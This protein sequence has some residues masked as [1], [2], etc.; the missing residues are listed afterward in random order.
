MAKKSEDIKGKNSC[1]AIKNDFFISYHSQNGG[2]LVAER[3]NNALKA[4]KYMSYYNAEQHTGELYPIRLHREVKNCKVLLW[5]LTKNALQEKQNNQPNWFFAELLWAVKYKKQIFFLVANN[6]NVEE[7]KKEDIRKKFKRSFAILVNHFTHLFVE[8]DICLVDKVIDEVLFPDKYNPDRIFTSNDKKKD[9]LPYNTRKKDYEERLEDFLFG[10]KDGLMKRIKKTP[11][12]KFHVMRNK[13]MYIYICRCML[14]VMFFFS[15]LGGMFKYFEYQKSLVI[16][17]GSQILKNGWSDVK[18]DGSKESPYQIDTAVALAYLA[19]TSQ[20]KSYKNT[21]FE[22]KEDITLN[23]YN[24]KGIA[25]GIEKYSELYPENTSENQ[26]VETIANVYGYNSEVIIN[27]DDTHEWLPIGCEE[28]PFEGSFDGNNHTI[29]GVYIEEDKDYQGFFGKCSKESRIENLNLVAANVSAESYVGA[30]VGETEG[31]INRCSV[32]SAMCEGKRYV[33]GV[34]GKTNIVVN[35]FSMSYITNSYEGKEG[36]YVHECFGGIAG[37]CNYLINSEGMCQLSMLDDACKAGGLVGEVEELAYNC[38]LL[39]TFL[40]SYESEYYVGRDDPITICDVFGVYDGEEPDKSL[41][42]RNAYNSLSIQMDKNIWKDMLKERNCYFKNIDISAENNLPMYQAKEKDFGRGFDIN[43][44]LISRAELEK[45]EKR[46]VLGA[47]KFWAHEYC[48]KTEGYNTISQEM[49]FKKGMSNQLNKAISG[50]EKNYRE[51][52]SI[53]LEYGRDGQML[54]LSDW[55]EQEKG[56]ED[57]YNISIDVVP[58]IKNAELAKKN[59]KNK[60]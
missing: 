3:I 27:K 53:L 9:G 21:Y 50:S 6:F 1:L 58:L 17:D 20:N 24:I 26:E 43:S 10:S 40:S 34:A 2:E 4:K 49:Q 39:G 5:L 41:I 28:Y 7:I 56:K 16:W 52:N 29:Y 46:T 30:L 15:M 33:G 22:L 12:L 48:T 37:Y 32:Y 57:F 19:S 11:K 51:L 42:Y 36:Q 13:K 59:W 47:G 18:G 25:N 14:C 35:T 55:A 60:K 44:N 31:L 38:I 54:S 45:V 8:D 23:Q